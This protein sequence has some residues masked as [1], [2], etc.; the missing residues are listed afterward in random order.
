M[1]VY[2][3]TSERQKSEI[4]EL[5]DASEEPVFVSIDC[6]GEEQSCIEYR[7]NSTTLLRWLSVGLADNGQYRHHT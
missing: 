1:F 6:A 3:V 2:Y 7:D 5:E 4:F